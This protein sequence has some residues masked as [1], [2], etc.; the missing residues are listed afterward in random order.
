[1]RAYPRACRSRSC[2]SVASSCTLRLAQHHLLVDDDE[3]A[4][5]VGQEVGVFLKV[6]FRRNPL[7]VPPVPALADADLLDEARESERRRHGFI[8]SA[9][10]LH[11]AAAPRA[12]QGRRGIPSGRPADLFPYT[13]PTSGTRCGSLPAPGAPTSG[14][15]RG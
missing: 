6:R 5:R 11:A 3:G 1:M 12:A 14:R 4:V 13:G 9:G 10:L 7:A 2:S 15:T 8:S